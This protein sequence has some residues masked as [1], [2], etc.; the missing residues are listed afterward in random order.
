LRVAVGHGLAGQLAAI[1]SV[2]ASSVLHG[3]GSL[4]SSGLVDK[5]CSVDSK[6]AG[7]G[8]LDDCWCSTSEGAGKGLNIGVGALELGCRDTKGGVEGISCCLASCGVL[9]L[10]A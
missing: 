9:R 2:R 5:G 6:W 4:Q 7:A 8:G 10:L 1:G 3:A